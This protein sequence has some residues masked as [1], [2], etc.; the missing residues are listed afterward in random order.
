MAN[1]SKTIRFDKIDALLVANVL[2]H[3]P[4]KVHCSSD[5]AVSIK[6][7]EDGGMEEFD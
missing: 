4:K 6:M 2:K 1:L 3:N 7:M 5:K